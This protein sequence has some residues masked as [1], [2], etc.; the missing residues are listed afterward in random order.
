MKKLLSE[1]ITA[2]WIEVDT[3]LV[4]PKSKEAINGL[5]KVLREDFK[6]DSDV[7]DYVVEMVR[8]T[9]TNFY[10]GGK[11]SGI[12]V[13]KNQTA[14]SAQLHPV[15]DDDEEDDDEDDVY[16]NNDGGLSEWDVT[17]LDG[18]DEE[19]E[20]ETEEKDE[21]AAAEDDIKKN[22][23]TALEKDKLKKE[24]IDDELLKTKLTNPTTGNPN[25]VSTLLGKKK[26]DPSAYSVAKKFLGDKG[27]SDDEIESAADS[28]TD[29][30]V[31]QSNGYT[32]N[33][34]KSLKQGDPTTSDVYQMELSPDDDE[35][36][37]RN[38]KFAN[39]IPPQPY[40]L[41]EDLVNNPKFPKKYLTALE[42][43]MNTKP[44]GDGT[45]WTHYSDIPG[46]AGQISAQAGE[47]MTMMGTSMN[48]D[49]FNKFTNSLLEHEA[50][51]IKDNPKLKTEGSR[52]VTKSWIKASQN[53]RKAI[54]NNIASE[55]P[56]AEVTATAW[57]TK[58][59][60]E[61]LGMTDYNK[62]KGFSTDMY[63]KLKTKD[64]EEIL[65]EVSLKK[66][67]E[68]NF[69]NSGAGKFNEWDSNLPDEINQNVYRDKQRQSL[70]STGS[71]LKS[72]VESLLSSNSPQAIEL[73]TMMESKKID[74]NQALED[75][76]MGK[77]SRAKSKVVLE[78]IK[79]LADSGNEIAKKHVD[80]VNSAHRKFQEKA[81]KA[82]TENPKMKA[83]MLKEIRSEFPL[84]AVSDGEETMAIGDN[85]LD[86]KVMR[87]IFG[88]DSY[89]EIKEKLSAQ[90]GPP[91][92]LGY[93]AEVGDTIIPLAE[94]KVRED[95]VGYGG[96]MK[97]EMTL[98]KR[99]AKILKKANEEIYS[100]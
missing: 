17:L 94:I 70:V 64:G 25:Q 61:A 36:E 7:I 83:G 1:I 34:D 100:K 32:G 89:D 19:E 58:D 14:V 90:P 55:F 79:A 69:L 13:G 91:P 39:P 33:K 23:L 99:F 52:I 59:D 97:F 41:P 43:M 56:N 22:A 62:N 86:K 42:R 51:L 4:N 77:G 93:K 71:K 78:A 73:K 35:F 76:K 9:P 18:L 88:T 37:N 26:S 21:K 27:V 11:T 72:E 12:D 46:G 20:S 65:K 3:K 44:T 82:I 68:V 31:K 66:S 54:L 15:W 40:K 48:D 98:D 6:F 95:G 5:K 29:E 85:S 47:L 96:Q 57:D 75:T 49:E 80:A 28:K 63:I 74:F 38:K 30:K 45:K 81:V 87:K 10:L 2:W 53:N 16:N 84:K 50:A 8:S 67:T 92:F 24:A 60:V